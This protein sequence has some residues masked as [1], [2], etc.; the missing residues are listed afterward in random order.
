MRIV[1]ARSAARGGSVGTEND[2]GQG[3]NDVEV[4]SPMIVMKSMVGI[5]ILKDC[6]PLDQAAPRAVHAPVKIFV[7]AVIRRQ[8]GEARPEGGPAAPD[9]DPPQDQ[10]VEAHDHGRLPPLEEDEPTMLRILH[11]VALALREDPVMETDVGLVGLR[12]VP[13]GPMQQPPMES[14]LKEIRVQQRHDEPNPRAYD[15]G[16]PD[17]NEEDIT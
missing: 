3:A 4:E 7:D 11:V 14:V 9:L 2:V 17:H 8:R 16:R 6:G 10:G 1:Y 5:E 13:M 12:E 15:V